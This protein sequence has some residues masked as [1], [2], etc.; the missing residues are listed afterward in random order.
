MRPT[1]RSGLVNSWRSIID[2]GF[3]PTWLDNVDAAER[4]PDQSLEA[5]G[6]SA[7]Q[8]ESTGKSA[9][10]WKMNSDGEPTNFGT[11]AIVAHSTNTTNLWRA[12]WMSQV[13]I[14]A[15]Q[16]N[17]AIQSREFGVMGCSACGGIGDVPG[18]RG[19]AGCA[20]EVRRE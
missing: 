2:V 3:I 11:A 14:A 13:G 4:Y 18:Y 1:V 20:V 9:V 7:I 19:A 5:Q 15:F 17:P 12:R 6:V 10:H 16:S 8:S